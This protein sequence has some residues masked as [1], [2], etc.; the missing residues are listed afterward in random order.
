MLL[1]NNAFSG[2][3]SGISAQKVNTS[4]TGIN[5]KALNGR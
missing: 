3:G 4:R 1:R 2:I 5:G